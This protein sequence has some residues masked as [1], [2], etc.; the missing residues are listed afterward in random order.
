[1]V[2]CGPDLGA[3]LL[4]GLHPDGATAALLHIHH[5]YNTFQQIVTTYDS[6]EVQRNIA[7]NVNC[8]HASL[9]VAVPTIS[10]FH[11]CGVGEG[12]VEGHVPAVI[13]GVLLAHVRRHDVQRQ[14]E[15]TPNLHLYPVRL[16]CHVRRGQYMNLAR[17]MTSA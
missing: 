16:E 11:D 17:E 15:Q 8:M 2:V 7:E 1:M 10:L 14:A 6:V 13:E 3:A 4:Y 9:C 12:D 5:I